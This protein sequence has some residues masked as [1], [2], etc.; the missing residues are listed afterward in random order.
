MVNVDCV[1][2]YP[3][4]SLIPVELSYARSVTQKF[5]ISDSGGLLPIR[6]LAGDPVVISNRFLGLLLPIFVQIIS[7]STPVL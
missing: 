1:R 3:R 5:K 6:G 2:S 4:L 7:L